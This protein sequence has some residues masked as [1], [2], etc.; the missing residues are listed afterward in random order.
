MDCFACRSSRAQ[1]CAVCVKQALS[2][3]NA[4]LSKVGEEKARLERAMAHGLA[5]RQTI[6]RRQDQLRKHAEL[7]ASLQA[8]ISSVRKGSDR[9]ARRVN[10][11]RHAVRRAQ[12]FQLQHEHELTRLAQKMETSADA[13]GFVK[14]NEAFDQNGEVGEIE[15][16]MSRRMT[17]ARRHLLHQLLQ[18]YNIWSQLSAYDDCM[19]EALAMESNALAEQPA[20]PKAKDSLSVSL[21]DSVRGL[22]ARA[23]AA[24]DVMLQMTEEAAHPLSGRAAGASSSPTSATGASAYEQWHA[25][26]QV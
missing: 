5:Q 1:L 15:A 21:A 3:R 8:E 18:Y 23:A 4:R 6:L 26:R 24:A 11:L 13:T 25:Q 16:R 2:D 7:K 22:A 20:A 14:S 9:L 12:D 19:R 10:E 17:D